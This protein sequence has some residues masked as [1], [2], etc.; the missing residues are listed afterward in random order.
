VRAAAMA[1][2]AMALFASGLAHADRRSCETAFAAAPLAARDGHYLAARD[3]LVQCAAD[4]CPAA[5]RPLCID[6]LK[7]LAPRIPSVVFVAR[8]SD[9]H[10]LVDVR[11]REGE[12]TL[13][14]KLDGRAVDLDP[15]AHTFRFETQGSLP[16]TS[17]VLVREGEQARPIVA[18]FAP[19][20]P[21]LAPPPAPAPALTSEGRR[22]ALAASVA[23]AGFGIEGITERS[24]L[25]G[26]IGHC[27]A[28]AVQTASTHLDIADGFMAA[29]LLAW[30]GTATLF[31]T[32]PH[33][34]P[35][36]TGSRDGASVGLW[37]SF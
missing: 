24:A 18:T 23:W 6:D 19:V 20:V 2:V 28:S 35:V 4:E 12:V 25:S 27:G 37:G 11:V 26:C 22:I 7:K 16:V 34:V 9:G 10:D 32:R 29:S 14:E 31:F 3:S 30:A 15:G 13:V 5:M 21:R 36:A 1:T 17:Q 8:G 33:V